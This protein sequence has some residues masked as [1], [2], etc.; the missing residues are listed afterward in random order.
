MNFNLA[1][2][3]ADQQ[4][5]STIF[6]NF[7]FDNVDIDTI[8]QSKDGFQTGTDQQVFR[9][10][11]G[12]TGIS[13]VLTSSSIITITGFI[14]LSPT[15]L[16]RILTLAN[17]R[18]ESTVSLY[19]SDGV[20]L[21]VDANDFLIESKDPGAVIIHTPS[22]A[23]LN[24]LFPANLKALPTSEV[25]ATT[26]IDVDLTNYAPTEIEFV[27][28]RMKI[29]ALKNDGTNFVL[30]EFDYN[31]GPNVILGGRI[32]LNEVINRSFKLLSGDEFNQ[33]I[34][35]NISDAAPIH[36]YQFMFPFMTRWEYWKALAANIEFFDNTKPNNNLNNYWFH[37]Q[38]ISS[39][40]NHRYCNP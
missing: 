31:F 4:K 39:H 16:A 26:T 8:P 23:K 1:C 13:T 5:T 10:A 27:Q 36:S 37:Y 12:N 20:T 25:I 29:I 22:F 34:F 11:S 15:Q 30:D 33:I 35:E 28:S 6:Q 21:L 24:T 14:K 38:K 2:D 19:G 9:G 17:K 7:C 40:Q 32:L 3:I 18:Y